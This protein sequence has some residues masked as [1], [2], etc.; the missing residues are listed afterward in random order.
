MSIRRI[1]IIICARTRHDT[2]YM[3][4]QYMDP[5]YVLHKLT[6]I[7]ALKPLGT[8]PVFEAQMQYLLPPGTVPDEVAVQLQEDC[9]PNK[10]ISRHGIA[11]SSCFQAY[12]HLGSDFGWC[13]AIACTTYVVR[14]RFDVE[15]ASTTSTQS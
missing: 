3:I 8:V 14:Y 11:F 15:D 6:M 5:A 9:T 13:F 10:T 1:V 7:V 2:V 12:A 4:V